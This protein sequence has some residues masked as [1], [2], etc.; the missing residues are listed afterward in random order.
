MASVFYKILTVSE[1]GELKA[2][3]SN[4]S[5]QIRWSGTPFDLSSGFIH[6]S[7]A[8]QVP[9]TISRFFG[10]HDSVVLLRFSVADLSNHD[11]RWEAPA[12]PPGMVVDTSVP[13]DQFPHIYDGIEASFLETVVGEAVTAAI[14]EKGDPVANVPAVLD[15]P[16][17]F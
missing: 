17:P 11:V 5:I 2:A 7:T 9:M 12:H 10:N 1:L 16:L 8:I 6:L 13:E 4:G 14:L 3:L 15:C